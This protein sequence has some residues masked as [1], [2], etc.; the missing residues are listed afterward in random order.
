MLLFHCLPAPHPHDILLLSSYSVAIGSP[1]QTCTPTHS[2]HAE[3]VVPSAWNTLLPS[4]ISLR[5]A[6]AP[7]GW[8]RQVGILL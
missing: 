4:S 5:K 2:D 7:R 1:A 8:K 6:V 3:P